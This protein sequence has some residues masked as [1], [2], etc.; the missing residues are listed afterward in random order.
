MPNTTMPE[1][2]T[3]EDAH[4]AIRDA[5]AALKAAGVEVPLALYKAAHALSYEI[6]NRRKS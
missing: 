2:S 3:I 5:I 6:A 1:I 4:K